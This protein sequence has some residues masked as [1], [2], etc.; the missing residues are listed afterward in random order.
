MLKRHQPIA[1]IAII[2]G[3]QQHRGQKPRLSVVAVRSPA[4][5]P[6]AN[7]PSTAAQ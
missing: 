6:S 4:A 5:V 7:V 1:G 3:E 2:A